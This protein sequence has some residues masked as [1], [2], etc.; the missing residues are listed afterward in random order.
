MAK[1]TTAVVRLQFLAPVDARRDAIP[2]TVAEDFV[3]VVESVVDG[4]VASGADSDQFVGVSYVLIGH[5]CFRGR[6]SRVW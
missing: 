3:V 4:S 5:G 1:S 6:F 2:H